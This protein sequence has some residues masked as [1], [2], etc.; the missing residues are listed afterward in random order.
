M[1]N[2]NTISTFTACCMMTG[3]IMQNVYTLDRKIVVHFKDV[4]LGYRVSDTSRDTTE[5]EVNKTFQVL[6]NKNDQFNLDDLLR[7]I[8]L[9]TNTMVNHEGVSLASF[10]PRY[11][12]LSYPNKAGV[13]KRESRTLLERTGR[14]YLRINTDC[15][16][17]VSQVSLSSKSCLNIHV[18]LTYPTN[19]QD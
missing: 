9:N 15:M 5:I 18:D 11:F 13:T 2:D 7:R 1:Q 10:T 14:N 8:V 17:D 6:I 3:K 12:E 19:M 16:I 4:T